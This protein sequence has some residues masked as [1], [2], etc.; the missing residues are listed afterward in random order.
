LGYDSKGRL[1]SLTN[2]LGFTQTLEYDAADNLLKRFDAFGK[3]VLSLSYN[4]LDNPIG[5][6]DALS[7]SSTFD[8]DELKTV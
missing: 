5:V 3:R 6:T 7:N 1:E 8:Y 2:P 4:E